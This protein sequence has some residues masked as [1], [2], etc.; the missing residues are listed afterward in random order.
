MNV[1]RP[2]ETAILE[3]VMLGIGVCVPQDMKIYCSCVTQR[4]LGGLQ[5]AASFTTDPS[6]D[7]KHL[8]VTGLKP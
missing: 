5:H 7:L 3:M 1:T 6:V 2:A 4:D 8:P